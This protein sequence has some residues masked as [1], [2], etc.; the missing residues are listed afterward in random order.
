MSE[1][2]AGTETSGH[3]QTSVLMLQ[4]D[5]LEAPLGTV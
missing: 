3:S 1:L 2:P 4:E 5:A